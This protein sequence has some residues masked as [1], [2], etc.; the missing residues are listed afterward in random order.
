M[1]VRKILTVVC[2]LG[3]GGTQRAAQNF[4]IGYRKLGHDSRVVGVHGGGVRAETLRGAGVHVWESFEELCVDSSEW[5]PDIVHFHSHALRDDVRNDIAM[6]YRHSKLIETNVFSYPTNIEHLLECSF[7]L[8]NWC[9]FRYLSQGGRRDKCK[10]LGNPVD[11][12]GFYRDDSEVVNAFKAKWNIPCGSLV[13]GRVGQPGTFNWSGYLIDVFSNLVEQ[14]DLNL[15]LL[16]CG[17]PQPI[18]ER[19]AADA[20]LAGKFTII[21]RFDSDDGLRACYS[22][23]DVMLHIADDGDT[24]GMAIAESLMCETP[25]ISLRTPWEANSQSEVI[26]WDQGGAVASTLDELERQVLRYLRDGSLRVSAGRAGRK[27]VLDNFSEKSIAERALRIVDGETIGDFR[28]SKIFRDAGPSVLAKLLLLLVLTVNSTKVRK[29]AGALLRR[30]YRY[31][32]EE[33][34]RHAQVRALGLS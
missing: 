12:D 24:F 17:P 25:V 22:A 5:M 4:A 33:S 26:G 1:P 18:R 3:L 23:M 29:F 16:L 11:S 6:R 34:G 9:A 13:V 8:A 28:L 14:H 32:F 27:H 15:H 19:L 20:Q 21:D 2:N 31:S 30:I 10:V 7:Q